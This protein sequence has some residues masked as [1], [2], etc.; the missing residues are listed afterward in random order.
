MTTDSHLLEDAESVLRRKQ[1]YSLA[2]MRLKAFIATGEGI[3]WK[4]MSAYLQYRAAGKPGMLPTPKKQTDLWN[5]IR[6]LKT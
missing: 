3:D 1:F 5:M 4:D 2:E 6:D